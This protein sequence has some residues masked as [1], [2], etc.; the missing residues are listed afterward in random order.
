MSTQTTKPVEFTLTLSEAERVELTRLL[1]QTLRDTDVEVHRT[2]TRDFRDLVLHKEGA[3]QSLLNK[4]R[5]A[6]ALPAP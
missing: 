1:E 4:L 3:L 6:K 2:H 5:Q